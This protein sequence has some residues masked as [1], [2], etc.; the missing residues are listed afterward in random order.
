MKPCT[1]Y[2]RVSTAG[3]VDGI[4]LESQ[5]ARIRAW[6][7]AN[8]YE[9]LAILHDDGISGCKLKNRPGAQ[10]AIALACE[11]KCPLVVYSLSRL[12]RST[13]EALDISEKMGKEGADIVSLCENL[14]TTTAAGKMIF[15]VLAVLA[16]FER[17]LVSER[18]K[19]AL[20]QKR[21][22]GQRIGGIEYGYDDVDG[23]LIPNANEQAVIA[24]ILRRHRAGHSYR[25]IARELNEQG[26]PSKRPGS[27]WRCN[28]VKR[29]IQRKG[30]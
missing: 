20:R 21:A 28:T 12:F 5:E 26:I 9:L 7:T 3:Q 17:D 16:E 10:K 14:D 25:G 23:R 29:I 22:N 27:T 24:Q 19:A 15:R 18:T 8:G 11:Q 1:G 13:R 2:I 6:A 30:E 4:S